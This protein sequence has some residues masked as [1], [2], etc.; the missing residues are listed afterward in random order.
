MESI[1]KQERGD[2]NVSVLD[3]NSSDGTTEWLQS[4]KDSRIT[5]YTSRQ[6]LSIE[7]NWA[8]IKDIPKNEFITL[9]GHDDL[10][11]SDYLQCMNQL[12]EQKPDAG[13][14][15]SHFRFIDASGATLS[16]CRPMK[17]IYSGDA[18]LEALLMDELDTMGT[19]Y[20]MR[21]K[22][23]DKLGGIPPYPNLLFADH[24]LWIGLTSKSYIAVHP[25]EKFSYRL[26]QSV[27]KTTGAVKY[28][29][30]YNCFLD[31][32][33]EISIGK[34]STTE[35]VRQATPILIQKY[36]QSLAHRLLRTPVSEREGKTV[37]AVIKQSK[38][39]A[40]IL[41]PNNS[42]NPDRL[43]ALQIAKWIDSNSL[44][45]NLYLAFRKAYSK[46]IY[47]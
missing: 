19:G 23:Y 33:K 31:F 44:L 41:S 17:A 29:N 15:Q 12:I 43:R 13:L 3:N 32:L 11:D 16:S 28:I 30:A 1:L 46:P 4:I 14:Y 37:A 39:A 8:R 47:S 6:S 40:D 22:D 10:L 36:C 18:F 9:I 5:I 21:S 35:V 7:Q 38:R 2:F 34:Q 20:M 45:R 27:S 42:F 25:S 26:N 24:A